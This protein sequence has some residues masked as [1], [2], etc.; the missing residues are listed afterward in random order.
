MKRHYII[1]IF[2]PHQGC[3]HDCIFCN[4]RKITGYQ[5][6][7]DVQEIRII[8][9]KHLATFPQE[10]GI[11]KEIA[12]Y[13]GSFTG[14]PL[15]EQKM[16]LEIA[17]QYKQ[18]GMVSGVRISTRPDTITIDR[19]HFLQ[20]HGVT[21]IELGVQSLDDDV[22]LKS[23][24]GHTNHDVVSAV[25]LIR[26]FNFAL[27]LQMMIG[28]PEDTPEKTLATAQSIAN[29]HPNFVRIYPTIIIEGTYLALLFRQGMYSP[30]SLDE[31]V[32]RAA[33]ILLIFEEAGIPVIRIGIQPTE[34]L[35]SAHGIIAGPFHPAFRELVESRIAY[36]MMEYLMRK[37]PLTPHKVVFRVHPRYL[38]TALG[39]KKG[40]VT[41]ISSEWGI[42]S[43]TVCPDD[44][45]DRGDVVMYMADGNIVNLR[46]TKAMWA[47]MMKCS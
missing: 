17:L 2:V 40:N 10:E 8:I 16:L 26:H 5:Q 11:Q 22:L 13:G 45:V 38:S 32:D 15:Q 24:R 3:P 42:A 21:V 12:F 46:I 44:A 41:K 36:D 1:P 30:L 31:A 25:S 20:E 18:R 34:E 39:N 29:L 43:I 35:C 19:L 9:E 37:L 6:R 28:L 27:G 47:K 4:Q 23:H 14:I 33:A 7:I